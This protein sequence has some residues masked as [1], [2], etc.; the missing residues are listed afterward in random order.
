MARATCTFFCIVLLLAFPQLVIFW[1]Y[2]WMPTTHSLEK[3]ASDAG[4][5][6]STS[7]YHAVFEVSNY[8]VRVRK[9]P[10]AGSS[11]S[12]FTKVK[13]LRIQLQSALDIL[14]KD[15]KQI[16][17]H[18]LFKVSLRSDGVND[19]E[20]A[21]IARGHPSMQCVMLPSAYIGNLTLW[22]AEEKSLH[23]KNFP[24]EKK[25]REVFYRG[26]CA[27]GAES[28]FKLMSIESKYLNVGWQVDTKPSCLKLFTTNKELVLRH[29]ERGDL[30][31]MKSNSLDIF[32]C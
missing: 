18:I 4:L 30:L 19:P 25:A 32:S 21:C 16:P 3:E 5:G 15:N 17:N 26:R 24:L 28:R 22:E 12:T 11:T 7:G 2:D 29:M 10:S 13:N 8:N 31:W 1:L 20:I 14:F 6:K 9:Y 23:E 27:P